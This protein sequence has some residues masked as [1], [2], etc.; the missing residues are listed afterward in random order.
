MNRTEPNRIEPNRTE[1]C[2]LRGGR[3]PN[4]LAHSCT[5]GFASGY[6]SMIREL[7]GF[8]QWEIREKKTVRFNSIQFGSIQFSH[9]LGCFQRFVFL[10]DMAYFEFNRGV[11]NRA[12]V[13]AAWHCE[14]MVAGR[15][16]GNASISAFARPRSLHAASAERPSSEAVLG[17]MQSPIQKNMKSMAVFNGSASLE[18]PCLKKEGRLNGAASEKNLWTLK[19]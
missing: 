8:I 14:A 1:K 4:Q 16:S 2:A 15:A 5:S 10:D 12:F 17:R 7:L 11:F 3:H 18:K 19:K 6:A 13:T 9:I